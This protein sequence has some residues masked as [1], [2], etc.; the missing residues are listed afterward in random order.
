V[1]P[2]AAGLPK[3]SVAPSFIFRYLQ[4][5]AWIQMWFYEQVN[6]QRESYISVFD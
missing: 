5:K 1:N 2:G 3:W 6:L 4:N